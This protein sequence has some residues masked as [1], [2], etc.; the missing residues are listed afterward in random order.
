MDCLVRLIDVRDRQYYVS[1][2]LCLHI[3]RPD[4]P[5]REEHERAQNVR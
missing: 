2:R 5:S 4:G 1:S 3:A